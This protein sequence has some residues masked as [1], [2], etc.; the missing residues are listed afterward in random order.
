MNA[1]IPVWSVAAFLCLNVRRSVRG[2]AYRRKI[3]PDFG[4]TTGKSGEASF[5]ILIKGAKYRVI[6]VVCRLVLRHGRECG[7]AG[8]QRFRAFGGGDEPEPCRDDDCSAV[9]ARILRLGQRGNGT[10]QHVRE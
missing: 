8:Q 6:D 2:Y 5:V 3:V 10:A 9:S 4:C 7:I 1:A